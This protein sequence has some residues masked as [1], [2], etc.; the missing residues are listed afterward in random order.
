MSQS[1]CKHGAILAHV[2]C[3]S[4]FIFSITPRLLITPIRYA[5]IIISV[6]M[7]LVP[8]ED[9]ESDEEIDT[10]RVHDA[11]GRADKTKKVAP[12]AGLVTGEDSEEE[13]GK[14]RSRTLIC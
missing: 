2:G 5:Y 4:L 1:R 7:S 12:R 8:G 10:D 9:T 13:D 14:Q 3:L 6:K 11:S